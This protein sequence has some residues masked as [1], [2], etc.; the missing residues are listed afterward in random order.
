VSRN[1]LESKEKGILAKGS[2]GAKTRSYIPQVIEY[3]EKSFVW[4][5]IVAILN[6]SSTQK[7]E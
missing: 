3:L 2:A 5:R 1:S 4:V 7:S 6:L